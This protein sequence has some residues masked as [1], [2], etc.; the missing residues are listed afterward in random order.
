[1]IGRNNP[2]GLRYSH[3]CRYIGLD[4]SHPHSKYFCN[5]VDLR[6]AI[7]AIAE[8]FMV[9]YRKRGLRTNSQLLSAFGL[10]S[11]RFYVIPSDIPSDVISFSEL[12]FQIILFNHGIDHGIKYIQKMRLSPDYIASVINSFDIEVYG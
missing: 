9:T 2:F 1:M 7:K 6:Y 11:I 5:F 8:L 12:F 4:M 10:N 3:S